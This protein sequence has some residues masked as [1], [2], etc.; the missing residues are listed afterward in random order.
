[1][2]SSALGVPIDRRAGYAI[3]VEQQHQLCGNNFAAVRRNAFILRAL[4]R[5]V[6]AAGWNAA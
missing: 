5:A 3:G 6:L 1:M 2:W 4:L